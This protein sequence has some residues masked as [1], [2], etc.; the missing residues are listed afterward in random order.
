MECRAAGLGILHGDFVSTHI[1]HGT[2]VRVKTLSALNALVLDFRRQVEAIARN[3][4]QQKCAE[5]VY[6]ILDEAVLQP[7]YDSFVDAVRREYATGPIES[8]RPFPDT[9][10]RWIVRHII[11]DHQAT[12]VRTQERDPAYD[13]GCHLTT[14][15]HRTGTYVLLYAESDAYHEVWRALPGVEDFAYWN[16]TDPPEGMS[17]ARWE[18]RRQR[19]HELLPDGVPSQSGMTITVYDPLTDWENRFWEVAPKD[20]PDYEARVSHWAFDRAVA[21]QWAQEPPEDRGFQTVFRTERWIKTP[22]GAERWDAIK[23]NIRAVI[24]PTWD[25][26]WA[27]RMLAQIWQTVRNA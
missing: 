14:I 20:I 11:A 18:R 25:G 2:R 4:Y 6:H 26:T 9:D 8:P 24:P 21:E 22:E 3:V 17:R 19:W 7:T 23:Q 13:W 15:P 1:E 16:H 27:H 5:L 10:L 12:I